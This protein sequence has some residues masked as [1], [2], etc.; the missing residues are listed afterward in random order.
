MNA[1]KRII[2]GI[3]V[4]LILTSI[5]LVYN[6][7]RR[8][9]FSEI[10]ERGDLSNLRLTIYFWHSHGLAEW[11]ITINDIKGGLY[12]YKIVVKGSD[13]EKHIDLLEKLSNEPLIP[14]QESDFDLL[15][16]YVFT[17]K[18]GHKLYDVAIWGYDGKAWNIYVNGA[19]VKD[20]DIFYD[21]I[22]PFL[23]QDAADLLRAAAAD[24]RQKSLNRTDSRGDS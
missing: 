2:L 6:I 22:L 7:D 16:Y 21:V 23:P 13:L 4:F 9:T 17:T 19:F 3:L 12:D 20:S 5:S 8:H 15:V 18:L 14:K 11:N 10:V 24:L 1:K